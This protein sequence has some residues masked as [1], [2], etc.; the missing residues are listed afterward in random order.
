MAT[1]KLSIMIHIE[2][3]QSWDEGIAM[4]IADL[5]TR[6]G[7][8]TAN[9]PRG[10]KLSLQ[11]GENF[12]K[13][14][15]NAYP[16]IPTS[17]SWVLSTHG[18]I[19][20]HGHENSFAELQTTYAYV[21]SAYDIE[22]GG[23]DPAQHVLG[24]SG[25]GPASGYNWTLAAV[26]LNLRRYNALTTE[27]YGN[28]EV[29]SR[30]YGMTDTE[31]QALYRHM[32]APGRTDTDVTTFRGRPF[33]GKGDGTWFFSGDDL[34]T[35][36]PSTTFVDSI[37]FIP[38]QGNWQIEAYVSKNKGPQQDR[39]MDDADLQAA[40]THIW[41]CYQQKSTSLSSITNVWYAHFPTSSMDTASQRS[42]IA[43]WVQSVNIMLDIG[44]ASPKGEGRNM[45]EI[46][47]IFSN[48]N[49]FYY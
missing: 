42:L 31:Q 16:G 38:Q 44:G 1:L 29:A 21:T 41:S 3:G 2:D 14:G 35:V 47:E 40:M 24:R 19:W 48:S 8:T 46:A 37:M 22:S 43:N 7:T 11:V 36:Y 28:V 23:Q 33:W 10:A 13:P 12:F 5:A 39:V 15:F 9:E 34:N 18:N 32:T 4:N 30:P 20:I 26:S 17:I 49:S 45:K 27:M 6:I 25:G